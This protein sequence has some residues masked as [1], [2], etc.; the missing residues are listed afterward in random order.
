MDQP[1]T[2]PGLPATARLILR[3]LADHP[4]GARVEDIAL[5][6][7]SRY[8]WAE[9]TILRLHHDGLLRRVGPNTYALQTI[10]P[11]VL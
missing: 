8:R 5:H 3:F 2:S 9:A 7:G 4:E 6:T 1:L 11:A 10:Q